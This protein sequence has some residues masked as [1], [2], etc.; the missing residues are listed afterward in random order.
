MNL[1][2]IDIQKG[3]VFETNLNSRIRFSSS[4]LTSINETKTILLLNSKGMRSFGDR[5]AIL[6]TC[7]VHTKYTVFNIRADRK[8]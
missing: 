3:H 4:F 6:T 2:V 5:Y 8:S 7:C 1:N